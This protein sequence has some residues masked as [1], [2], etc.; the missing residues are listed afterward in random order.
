MKNKAVF[1]DRDGVINAK[2]A[3][4][5]YVGSWEEFSIFPGVSEAIKKLNDAGFLV[6]VVTNQRGIATGKVQVSELENIHKRLVLHLADRGAA[7]HHI[8]YCPHD[9]EKQCECRKPQP[10]M[11]LTAFQDFEIDPGMS[12]MIGD[13]VSDVSAGQRAGC[14]T[15]LITEDAS[16]KSGGADL[17]VQSLLEAAHQ[18]LKFDASLR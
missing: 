14:R 16:V 3:A 1:L 4:G 18:L 8:Y 10:G 5:E 15:V 13:T 12:W 17:K 9:L 2:A 11:L 6:V 7:I